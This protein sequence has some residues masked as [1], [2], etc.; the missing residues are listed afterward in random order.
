MSTGRKMFTVGRYAAGSLNG[1]LF[2][3][4]AGAAMAPRNETT[5]FSMDHG[6][7]VPDGPRVH[8][9]LSFRFTLVEAPATDDVEATTGTTTPTE[10][11]PPTRNLHR[12]WISRPRSKL[13]RANFSPGD[14]IVTPADRKVNGS[15]YCERL[16]GTGGRLTEAD[17]SALV[18]RLPAASLFSLC[19]R[20]ASVFMQRLD[21]GAVPRRGVMTL[22]SGMS[23]V[24]FTCVAP[25][26]L[27]TKRQ[28]DVRERDHDLMGILAAPCSVKMRRH[29]ARLAA[30]RCR[31]PA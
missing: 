18:A 1:L 4:P 16:N 22:A 23:P 10:T 2:V 15:V 5:P 24:I 3:L 17:C 9:L 7:F 28:V 12:R 29:P 30:D 21:R 14:Q 27:F 20:C 8:G 31:A 19:F 25:R 26:S 11:I 6:V 13:E